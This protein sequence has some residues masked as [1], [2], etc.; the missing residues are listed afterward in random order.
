VTIAD[1]DQNGADHDIALALATAIEAL[2]GQQQAVAGEVFVWQGA[3]TRPRTPRSRAT[4][5]RSPASALS[6]VAL[7]EPPAKRSAPL[8]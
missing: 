3:C 6:A 7:T 5:R 1:P 8:R 2:S 4:K